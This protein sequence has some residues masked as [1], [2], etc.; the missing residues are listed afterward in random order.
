MRVKVLVLDSEA[1]RPSSAK[2]YKSYKVISSRLKRQRSTVHVH[3]MTN[4][5]DPST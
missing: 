4:A 2:S 3:N 5:D 1:V